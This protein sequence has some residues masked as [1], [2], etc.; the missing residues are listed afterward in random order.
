M[1][2]QAAENGESSPPAIAVDP[3]QLVAGELD[4]EHI[5][6]L[7]VADGVEHRDADVAARRGAVAA[8]EEHRRGE[9]HRGGLAVGAGDR[10]P[11]GRA[12]R[13][14][15]AGARRARCR[16][17]RRC[18]ARRAQSSSGWSWWKPGETTTSSGSNVG[19]PL[20]RSGQVGLLD[21]VGADHLEQ[22]RA[23]LVGLRGDDEHLGAQ[24]GERVGDREPGDAEAVARPRAA[25][26][27]RRA[28]WSARRGARS[29]RGHVREPLEVEASRRRRRRAARR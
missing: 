24:L 13:P 16:P 10:D 21:E 2:R 29:Q 6:A 28:S 4:D 11:V 3:V 20:G 14:C 22:H 7:R 19:E 23:L 12:A 18:R 25:R 26:S 15:R 27:S 9:L 1:F 17:R 5:E 8:G